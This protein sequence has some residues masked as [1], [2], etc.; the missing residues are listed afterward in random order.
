ML[1]VAAAMTV[2]EIAVEPD[3][4][5]TT[6]TGSVF[7]AIGAPI[8]W[9]R[10]P[11]LTPAV[12]YRLGRLFLAASALSAAIA[13]Y[14]WRGTPI[15]GAVAFYFVMV[16]VFAALFFERRDVLGLIVLETTL[17]AI[18]LL[19]D[20]PTADDLVLG[21]LAMSTSAAIGIVLSGTRAAAEKLSYSDALTGAANRREWDLVVAVAAARPER[22]TALSLL[23]ID[24]DHFKN[25]NDSDGHERGDEVL[26]TVVAAWR[27]CVRTNDTV[28]RLGGDEFGVLL[29]DCDVD[30]ARRVAERLLDAV[31]TETGCTCSIGGAT[32]SGECDPSLLT[33]A[34]DAALYTAKAAGRDRAHVTDV[35]AD[36]PIESTSAR[37]AAGAAQ[38]SIIAR[39]SGMSGALGSHDRM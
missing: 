17:L 27:A 30:R 19:A 6:L 22:G 13:V 7:P 39:Q 26:R 10:G 37:R 3:S 18:A 14:G 38:P 15:A 34:A 8:A 35:P 2:L 31:R 1:A 20:G 21:L 25:V 36:P 4:W 12:S 11:K 5:R 32:T 24:I 16:M 23:L 28:A 29:P 33:T 9:W